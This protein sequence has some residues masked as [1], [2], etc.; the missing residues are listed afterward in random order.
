MTAIRDLL[1]SLARLADA[2]DIAARLRYDGREPH[3]AAAV[4]TS[5]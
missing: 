3:R 2:S 4:L 1:I 5:G